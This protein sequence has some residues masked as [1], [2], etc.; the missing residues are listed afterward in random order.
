MYIEKSRR[1]QLYKQNSPVNTMKTA[2]IRQ[3]TKA[4]EKAQNLIKS[5]TS[6]L[7]Q[8]MQGVKTKASNLKK[9]YNEAYEKGQDTPRIKEMKQKMKFGWRP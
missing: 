5:G 2:A 6:M 8:G 3:A 4:Q 9:K 1:G 7:K